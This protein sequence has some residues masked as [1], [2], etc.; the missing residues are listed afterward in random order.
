MKNDGD[1]SIADCTYRDQEK[2]H[3]LFVH[4]SEYKVKHKKGKHV[5]T[6]I[7]KN[8]GFFYD[9]DGT[10]RSPDTSYLIIKRLR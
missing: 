1:V 3:G 9:E 8:D 2:S 5:L 10:Q 6:R 4:L 7:W